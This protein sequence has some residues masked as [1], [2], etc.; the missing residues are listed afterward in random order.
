MFR[1]SRVSVTTSPTSLCPAMGKSNDPGRS[2]VVRNIS[3]VEVR[4]GGPDVTWATG[5]PLLA[6][7]IKSYEDLDFQI[8]YAVVQTGTVEVAVEQEGV[9]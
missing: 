6:G 2:V 7:E 1:A 9:N 8:P 5:M 3:S 4:T